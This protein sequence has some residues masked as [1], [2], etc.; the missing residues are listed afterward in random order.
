MTIPPNT[1]VAS[2]GTGAIASFFEKKQTAAI[3]LAMLGKYND[4]HSRL[5][6]ESRSFEASGFLPAKAG[7]TQ[8]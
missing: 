3:V 2:L 8:E 7:I 1:N 4:C 5:E 6:R